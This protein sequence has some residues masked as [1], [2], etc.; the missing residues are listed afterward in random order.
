MRY[1][2]LMELKNDTERMNVMRE[3]LA[4]VVYNAV[5]AE[6]GEEYSRY[7]PVKI[8]I[9]ENASEVGK[10]TVVVDVADVKDKDG[11][12]VGAVAEISIKIKKWN[13]VKTKKGITYG[14]SLDDYDIGLAK[15]ESKEDKGE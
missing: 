2:D 3:R 6:Y 7:I 4:K 1:T 10:N 11:F 5:C 13:D 14:V 9:T 12:E 8:G 15:H